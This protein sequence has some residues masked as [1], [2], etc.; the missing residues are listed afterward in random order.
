MHEERWCHYLRGCV[1]ELHVC[2][3]P[4]HDLWITE[5]SRLHGYPIDD[6]LVSSAHT[7]GYGDNYFLQD[8]NAPWCKLVIVKEWKA[9]HDVRT[10]RQKS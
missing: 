1:S 8:D 4:E 3:A 2:W 6:L 10:L 5:C 9:Q 7:L